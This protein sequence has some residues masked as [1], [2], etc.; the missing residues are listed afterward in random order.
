MQCSAVK[1][2]R[3]KFISVKSSAVQCSS[4]DA[5]HCSTVRYCAIQGNAVQYRWVQANCRCCQT[6]V[7]WQGQTNDSYFL[8][9]QTDG[10]QIIL[11][12][13][14]SQNID[15][16]LRNFFPLARLLNFFSFFLSFW[17]S[18]T[19]NM[20]YC[21]LFVYIY[22]DYLSRNKPFRKR[23]TIPAYKRVIWNNADSQGS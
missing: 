9:K 23:K 8:D 12:P 6:V 18:L 3:M 21:L 20:F 14:S 5:L 15:L 1:P 7:S 17:I 13:V 19:S 4:V 10:G 16:F 11:W 2:T 22:F